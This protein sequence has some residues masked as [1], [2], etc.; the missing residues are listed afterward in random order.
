MKKQ[1][2]NHPI[3]L[4]LLFLLLTKLG[5]I[6]ICAYMQ[7]EKVYSENEEPIPQFR[8]MY[9]DQN[10]RNII[11]LL[12]DVKSENYDFIIKE[13]QGSVAGWDFTVETIDSERQIISLN[14]LDGSKMDFKYEVN[15]NII[16]P[17]YSHVSNAGYFLFS[18]FIV[19]ILLFLVR[20]GLN[21]KINKGSL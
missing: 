21:K 14:Y 15:K 10:G 17:I 8:V 6:F 16:K 7:C 1:F 19:F 3:S 18:G 4:L 11:G 2:F 5:M 12:K 13:G 9:L 20:L